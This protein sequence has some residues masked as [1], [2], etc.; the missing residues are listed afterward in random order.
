MAVIDLFT[1][2]T[3]NGRKVHIMLEECGLRYHVT[4]V[5]ITRGEQ[6]EARFVAVNPNARIPAI[7]DRN[8][9]GRKPITIFESGAILIYL[10]EKSRRFLPS[11]P[12]ERSAVLQ[13]LMWQMGNFG[14]M[15]GQTH[16]FRRYAP[17]KIPYAIDRY[18]NEASRLYAVLDEQLSRNEYV[19]GR[20][21][22]AD[23]AIF[24]WARLWK[25]LRARH[26]ILSKRRPL[27]GCRGRAAGGTA[28]NAAAIG[29][30]EARTAG[31]APA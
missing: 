11:R 14:P 9:P 22:I 20:Y 1:W 8:G 19:A 23:M 5:D 10:A 13:W 30:V 18:T 31:P 27:D 29:A 6:H 16:H 4:T 26:G 12:R 2:D 21:S 3:P 28:W 24:P 7:V 25:I 15:L 17:T